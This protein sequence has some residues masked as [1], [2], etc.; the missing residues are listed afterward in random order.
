MRAHN[1]AIAWLILAAAS[2]TGAQTVN[3]QDYEVVLVP[4]AVDVS[5]G[6]Y[7]TTWRTSFSLYHDSSRPPSVIGY[8]NMNDPF[9]LPAMRTYSPRLYTS[10][11]GDQPGAL[12]YISRSGAPQ[13]HFDLHFQNSAAS[14]APV[15]LPVVP[16]EKLLEGRAILLRVPGGD[17]Q[18]RTLRI[19]APLSDVEVVVRVS[20][21]DEA[22]GG[23]IGE[24]FVTLQ[25]SLSAV[26]V[27]GIP[28]KV[29]PTAIAM[30]LDSAF[31]NITS[32]QSV[33]VVVEP[34]SADTPF[35]AFVA[36]TSNTTQEVTLS[37]PN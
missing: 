23:E 9:I 2:A 11:P 22:L 32:F 18:R 25:P 31:P 21:V 24:Q 34:L 12:L 28:F 3:P 27:T 37:L 1:V 6:S 15:A 8:N 19:Y 13:T 30:S 4:L 33:T 16:E 10:G 26:T 35:W 20:V 29:H 7:G 17:G 5:P 14:S 36:A